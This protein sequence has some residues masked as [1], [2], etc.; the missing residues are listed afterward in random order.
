MEMGSVTASILK[1][2]VDR[3][4]TYKEYSEIHSR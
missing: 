3:S 2:H 4:L 1:W